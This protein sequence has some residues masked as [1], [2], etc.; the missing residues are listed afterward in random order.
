MS[1]DEHSQSKFKYP[2]N[3][4]HLSC[5]HKENY[6]EENEILNGCSFAWKYLKFRLKNYT[7]QPRPLGLY[8]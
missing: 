8:E 7:Y 3:T 5:L 6:D 4:D 2:E 1:K